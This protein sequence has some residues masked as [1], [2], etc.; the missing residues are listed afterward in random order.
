MR[1]E[2]DGTGW[3]QADCGLLEVKGRGGVRLQGTDSTP[4]AHEVV[5]F[6][7]TGRKNLKT[8]KVTGR[9][10]QEPSPSL[11]STMLFSLGTVQ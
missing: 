10:L 6:D 2:A 8:F 7:L 11:F 9:P 3:G 5:C 4:K 1:M